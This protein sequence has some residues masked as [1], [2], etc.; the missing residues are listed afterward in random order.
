MTEE[1]RDIE[2]TRARV[3]ARTEVMHSHNAA[4][5]RRYQERGVEQVEIL[6]DD[7][8]PICRALVADNPYPASEAAGLV[9]G[10]THPRCECTIIPV[11]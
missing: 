9:P 4:A 8:C 7:P 6:P 3:L 5:A 1:I 11:L 2:A 10:R